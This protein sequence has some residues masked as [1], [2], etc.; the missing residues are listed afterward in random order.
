MNFDAEGKDC[1][2]TV[3]KNGELLVDDTFENIKN[4]TVSYTHNYRK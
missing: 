1:L 2:Q 4:R 3:F